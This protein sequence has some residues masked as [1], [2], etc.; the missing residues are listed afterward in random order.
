MENPYKLKDGDVDAFKLLFDFLKHLTTLS[1]GSIL[2]LITLAEKFFTNSPFRNVL[3]IALAAFGWSILFALFSMIIIS[4][5]VGGGT[6][7]TK[8]LNAFTSGFA[9]S[10]LGFF[11][12]MVLIVIAIVLQ[13]G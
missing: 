2:V 1:S 8:S 4:F 7:S 13:Y 11:V 3:F 12:G 9:M 6:F 10:A 5:N